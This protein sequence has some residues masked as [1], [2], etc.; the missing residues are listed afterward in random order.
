MINNNIEESLKS[1]FSIIVDDSNKESERLIQDSLKKLK[2]SGFSLSSPSDFNCMVAYRIRA[3]LFQLASNFHDPV[4]KDIKDTNKPDFIFANYSFLED[5]IQHLCKI[6]ENNDSSDYSKSI[7]DMY[8]IYSLTGS[9]RVFDRE[10]EYKFCPRFGTFK[11][12]MN[13]CDSLYYLYYGNPK[14]YFECY[15]TL[16][17]S[18][19]RKYK[20]LIHFWTIEFNDG[21]KIKF[22]QTFDNRDKN[23]LDNGYHDKGSYYILEKRFVKNRGYKLYDIYIP[24]EERN[25]LTSKYVCIPKTD[26]KRI[27]KETKEKMI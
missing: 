9:I 14:T 18:E 11:E 19:V 3:C 25:F 6:K 26:I 4:D 27:Y 22:R 23:P 8:L 1:I 20:H 13:F 10:V 17:K 12:W 21:E 15:K 7:L 2:E 5:H 16:L 24:E